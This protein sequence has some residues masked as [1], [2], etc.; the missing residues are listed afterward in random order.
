MGIKKET[1]Q[2]KD[3]SIP[4][5]GHRV[6]GILFLSS[7]P[8][9]LRRLAAMAGLQDP[10][11][12]RSAVSDLN[13]KYDAAGRAFRVEEV[14]GGVQ[15]LTRPQFSP[16]LRR[17]GQ[18]AG[19]QL[20]SPGMLETLAI[21]AYRQPVVRA[22]VEA[23]RGVGSD[24]VLRQLMQRDLVRIAGRHEELGRPYLYETTRRF[25]QL[26][27]LQS[28][29]NLPRAQKIRAAE[30]DIANR[31]SDPLDGEEPPP[32]AQHLEEGL[33]QPPLDR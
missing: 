12:A 33:L 4:L 16:W 3:S 27:G 13:A 23:I 20:L 7:E 31:L 21:I 30:A 28:L 5:A 14:A 26:F 6:E 19:E 32:N 1:L 9:T 18:V 8:I 24:E 2:D 29:D 15:M 17:F 11:A 22:E 25:L 10:T